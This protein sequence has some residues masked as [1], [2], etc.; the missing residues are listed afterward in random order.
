MKQIEIMI[1]TDGTVKIEGKEFKGPECA[2]YIAEIQ[3][4]LGTTASMKKKPEFQACVTT[5][6]QLKQGR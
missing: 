3:E 1:E 4:A 6:Q 5:R 2:K